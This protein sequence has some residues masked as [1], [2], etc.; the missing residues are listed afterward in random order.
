MTEWVDHWYVI[1]RKQLP[2][3][4]YLDSRIL[5]DLG[6]APTGLELQEI[7]QGVQSQGVERIAVQH[8]LIREPVP[9]A[10]NLR[11]EW[12]VRE[13]IDREDN[14]YTIHEQYYPTFE[15]ADEAVKRASDPDREV[16]YRRVTTWQTVKEPPEDE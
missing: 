12:A 15:S 14:L 16:V 3:S 1:G 5:A 4:G 10:P 11:I 8:T 7:M 13:W 6:H 2:E 9:T